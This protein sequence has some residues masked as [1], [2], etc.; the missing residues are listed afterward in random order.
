MKWSKEDI[1]KHLKRNINDYSAAVIVAALY[2]KIYGEFPSI[3]LSG[4]QAEFANQL[5][6]KL[7]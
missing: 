3:G 5:Y 6:N 1:N 2:K 7:P 4:A